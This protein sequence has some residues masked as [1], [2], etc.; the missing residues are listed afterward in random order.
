MDIGAAAGGD[1][2]MIVD[3]DVL[4]LDEV[5]ER[6]DS[7]ADAGKR[8]RARARKRSRKSGPELLGYGADRMLGRKAEK[9]AKMLVDK[10]VEGELPYLKL[11]VELLEGGEPQA[12]PA[13]KRSGRT[14]ACAMGDRLWVNGVWQGAVGDEG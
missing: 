8:K 6:A 1:G 14:A 7:D 5:R 9:L 13:Q 2:E 10:A 11:L 4:T 3:A 12:D